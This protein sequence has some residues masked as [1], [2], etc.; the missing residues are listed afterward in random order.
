MKDGTKAARKI[1]I[2]DDQNT[3]RQALRKVL[4]HEG[5]EVLE[6][7]NADQAL[8]Q[9]VLHTP[10]LIVLDI[11]MPGKSGLQVSAAIKSR[12]EYKKVPIVLLS[13]MG[14]KGGEQELKAQSFADAFLS[15]PCKA[16]DILA[17]IDRLF[18][19]TT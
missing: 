6:A 15:K 13:A 11:M 17:V 5:Y 4:Q 18:G 12:A 2:V 1:L 14:A 3:V 16:R 7:S 8:S 10:D 9:T 19:K